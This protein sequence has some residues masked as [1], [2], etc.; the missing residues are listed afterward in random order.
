[1]TAAK[2][3]PRT[4][5]NCQAD[6]VHLGTSGARRRLCDDCGSRGRICGRCKTYKEL[7]HFY[8]RKSKKSGNPYCKPCALAHNREIRYGIPRGTAEVVLGA[9]GDSCGA[10]GRSDLP[11][12]V[13]HCHDS[14]EIRGLLCGPC[15]SGLGL[16]QD[17]IDAMLGAV[18]YLKRHSSKTTA[19]E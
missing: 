18:A 13:D 6:Y 15:N 4:C 19:P 12:V 2:R 5:F 16:F 11:L 8:I 1:M 10:C 7:S 14:G 3:K 9:Y 17:N